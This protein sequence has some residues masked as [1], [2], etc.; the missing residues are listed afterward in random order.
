[1]SFAAGA[2][3]A[4]EEFYVVRKGKIRLLK[5]AM[6]YGPNSSGKTNLLLA[7]DWL[8]QF[9]T[10][11][12]ANKLAGTG[13]I[14]FAFTDSPETSLSSF[15][16]AFFVGNTEYIYELT[17]NVK[18]V[19]TEKLTYYASTQPALLFDR[20]LDEEDL[21]V[22]TFGKKADL[23][24][25]EQQTLEG[26]TISNQ[27]VLASYL[28]ANV[29]SPPL[30]AAAAWFQQGLR[31]LVRPETDL[32]LRYARR[33][34]QQPERQAFA[35]K[36]LSQADFNVKDLRIDTYTVPKRGYTYRQPVQFITSDDEGMLLRDDVAEPEK[37]YDI[38]FTHETE[39]GRY[40]L[41]FLVQSVGTQRYFGL[42]GLLDELM[43]G[44][45]VLSI[46]ELDASMH[47][48]LLRF[49]LLIARSY[50]DDAQFIFTIH[51]LEQLRDDIFRRDA[52]WFCEKNE[53]G[54]TELFSLQDFKR[55]K[56]VSDYN[57]YRIGK[58]G[59][60]PEV[61]SANLLQD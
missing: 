30:A 22:I 42:I 39:Q 25:A 58:L 50:V 5:M 10:L 32:T 13:S 55:H 7:L 9:V 38:F 56:N 31:P 18:Q 4:H 21:A 45:T 44:Q 41:P 61:G 17:L 54:A 51:D 43:D 52:V 48:E 6:L 14:P 3:K 40:S 12:R 34:H 24:K 46:D 29:A 16:L 15:S 35:L 19:V 36:A 33:L 60:F 53:H 2:G 11:P 57:A 47:P 27:S 37:G 49:F 23:T 28:K 59:A 26:I 20:R 8:R 1:M